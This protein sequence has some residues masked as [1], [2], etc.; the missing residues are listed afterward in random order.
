M[1]PTRRVPSSVLL[2]VAVSYSAPAA[3]ALF[4]YACWDWPLSACC[5][6]AIGAL[7]VVPTLWGYFAPRTA[8]QSARTIRRFWRNVAYTT[9]RSK[10]VRASANGADSV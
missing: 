3:V 4:L 8:T 10:V 1:P 9:D 2:M 7:I 6:A 5:L